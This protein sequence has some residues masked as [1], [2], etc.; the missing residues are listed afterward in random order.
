MTSLIIFLVV[1]QTISSIHAN[2]IMPKYFNFTVTGIFEA[3]GCCSEIN[4]ILIP[5]KITK[6]TTE[7]FIYYNCKS[8]EKTG[9]LN[10]DMY[11]IEK[12]AIVECSSD[13]VHLILK[14][15]LK[16][17]RIDEF[18]Y[19]FSKNDLNLKLVI[20]FLYNFVNDIQDYIH[21]TH[22][23]LAHIFYQLVYV[24]RVF[25][26]LINKIKNK[27]NK[28]ETLELEIV[29][30]VKGGSGQIEKNIKAKS[31]IVRNKKK[32][33]FCKCSKGDCT[34]CICS[35]NNEKCSVKCHNKKNQNCKNCSYQKNNYLTVD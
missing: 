35:T 10:K 28:E 22:G 4:S 33:F 1:F 23:I 14:K 25:R 29:E 27:K 17:N 15:D 12:S 31:T 11:I 16:I 34:D 19:V 7:T 6:C 8:V 32:N 9:F 24:H 3:E 20:R 5:S 21:L 13:I 18:I 26:T 2:P 30:S